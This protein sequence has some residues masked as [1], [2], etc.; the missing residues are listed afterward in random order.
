[1]NSATVVVR[2]VVLSSLVTLLGCATPSGLRTTIPAN[3][4]K[5]PQTIAVHALLSSA[6]TRTTHAAIMP[7]VRLS[8]GEVYLA[9]PA[10]SELAIAPASQMMTGE[11]TAGLAAYGFDLREL[12][13][14]TTA[15]SEG[16]VDYV[17][18]LA[19]LDELRAQHGLEAVVVGN[20]FFA[21]TGWSTPGDLRVVAAYLKVVDT[22][23]LEVLCQVTMSY[24]PYGRDLNSVAAAMA[25]QLAIAA[26]LGREHS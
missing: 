23:T 17:I 2:V 10:D 20:V 21:S 26:G 14:E 15:T 16:E 1:M 3:V 8:M 18:S 11:L 24:D 22:A 7:E 12:P 9:P 4:E 13:Y 19:L 5:I 25:D 6:T